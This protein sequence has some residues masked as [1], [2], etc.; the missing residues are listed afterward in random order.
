MSG[1]RALG[2]ADFVAGA[3]ILVVAYLVAVS[4]IFAAATTAFTDWWANSV[5]FASHLEVT[6]LETSAA[7]APGPGTTPDRIDVSPAEQPSPSEYAADA[8][9]TNDEA[10]GPV[11]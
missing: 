11:G 5:S 3:I 9:E 4:G 10:A 6:S 7:T 2:L 8:G 1:N